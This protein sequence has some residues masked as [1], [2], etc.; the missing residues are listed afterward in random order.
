MFEPLINGVMS[1]LGAEQQNRRSADAAQQAQGFSA[2]QFASRYQTTVNDMQS[3]GLNPMLAYSQGG[4]SPPSGVQANVPANSGSAASAGYMAGRLNSAQV[5]LLKA[6]TES[7][8]ADAAKKI[9]ETR[10]VD[11]LAAA[12]IDL[13]HSSAGA[14]RGSIEFMRNQS[15]KIIEEIRNIPVEGQRLTALVRNLHESSNL[16]EK[17]GLTEVQK[18]AQ[19]EALARKT[20]NEADLSNLDVSAALKFDNFGREAGQYKSIIDLLKHLFPSRR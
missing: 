13:K 6:Q 2:Q 1:W 15:N 11:P 7:A 8:S 18:R 5:D 20:F 10:Q 19:M 17:Q 9:V 3:A 14:A 4:G 16:L 12:D